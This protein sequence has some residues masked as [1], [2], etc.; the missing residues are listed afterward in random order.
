MVDDVLEEG[1]NG[2]LALTV[3]TDNYTCRLRF[4]HYACRK[5]GSSYLIMI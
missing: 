2:A 3:D 1:L 5:L 4:T